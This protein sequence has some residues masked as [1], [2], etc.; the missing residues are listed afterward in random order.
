M[1]IQTIPRLRGVTFSIDGRRFQ[2]DRLGRVSL[3]VT[4]RAELERFRPHELP[5]YQ[6]VR[7]SVAQEPVGEDEASDPLRFAPSLIRQIQAVPRQ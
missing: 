7:L 2:S 3:P 1:V 5:A 4:S 6:N